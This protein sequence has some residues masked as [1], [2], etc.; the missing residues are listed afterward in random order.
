MG[1]DLDCFVHLSHNWL[2][3]IYGAFALAGWITG[4][5]IYV[6]L[7]MLLAASAGSSVL[8]LRAIV[9]RG[10]HLYRPK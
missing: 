9:R 1:A 6:A 8:I 7:G 10:F 5:W 3:L 2:F 4:F